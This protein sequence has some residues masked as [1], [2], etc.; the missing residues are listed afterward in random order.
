MAVQ[1]MDNVGIVVDDLP[2]T[3]A[4]FGELGPRTRRPS[5]DRWRVGWARRWTARPACRDRHDAYAG[6]SQPALALAIYHDGCGC[7]SPE[8][9]SE[10][11]RLS[12]RDV[13]CGD[14][15]KTLSR[16][17]K[18]GAQLGE[19]VQYE[20]AY[21]LCY[22][23]GPEGLS[24]LNGHTPLPPLTSSLPP[25]TVP[26]VARPA[27]ANPR[28]RRD[29]VARSER[30]SRNDAELNRRL[31]IEPWRSAELRSRLGLTRSPRSGTF[32]GSTRCPAGGD[33]HTPPESQASM[34]T[35]P[36]AEPAL[37]ILIDWYIFSAALRCCA[38]GAI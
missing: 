1:R 11:S 31:L 34:L 27:G 7:R 3:I 19:V 9:P 2:A 32:R 6:R 20:G 18:R 25:P 15:D 29:S 16:L 5:R 24:H 30:N 38:G 37:S 14:I 26:S 22:I 10:R 8:C 35:H 33:V 28:R 12:A 21:R 4:F 23:R 13:R 36:P 17:G